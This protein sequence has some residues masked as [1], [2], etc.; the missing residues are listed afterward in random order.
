MATVRPDV[1]GSWRFDEVTMKLSTATPIFEV[2]QHT[3]T[4]VNT[5]GRRSEC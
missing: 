3:E 4:S 2:E 1:N 5:S